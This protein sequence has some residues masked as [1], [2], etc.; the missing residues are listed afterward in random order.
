[1]E[2]NRNTNEQPYLA[3]P[4]DKEDSKSNI[5]SNNIINNE[6]EQEQRQSEAKSIKEEKKEKPVK[7]Y[8]TVKETSENSNSSKNNKKTKRIRRSNNETSSERTF[9]CTD[10][11]KSY[12]SGAALIN[13][14]KIKH[15]YSTEEEKK[16]RGRPKKENQQERAYLDAK[17]KYSVFFNDPKRGKFEQNNDKT[18]NI[19]L[20]VIKDSFNSIFIQYKED[21]FNNLENIENYSLYQIVI[22][23]WDKTKNDF[24][25]ES[26]T[27]NSILKE[28]NLNS[29]IVNKGNQKLVPLDYILFLYLKELGSKT[30]ENYHLFVNK[31]IVLLR[32]FVNSFKKEIVKKE[33]ENGNEKEYSQ[34]YGAENIPESFNDFFLEFIQPKKYFGLDGGELIELTQH[35]C[36][37]LYSNGFTHSYLTLL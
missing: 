37:W 1:M 6:K 8:S 35:F 13:H 2:D 20:G 21:L 4:I 29:N 12:L 30:N 16:S 17:I 5:V 7:N 36:F 15:G 33:N 24:P 11:N 31:F 27:D 28:N 26:L 19:N 25:M 18:E 32:E 23:N 3:N 22:N 9:K 10:C 14:K 34:L